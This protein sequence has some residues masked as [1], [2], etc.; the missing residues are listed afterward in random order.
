M[1]FADKVKNVRAKLLISQTE[2]AKKIG[3]S[4]ETINRWE[5]GKLQPS[6]LNE[7]RFEAFC[8]TEKINFKEI[9]K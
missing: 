1:N 7:K 5:T 8:E 6:F 3:V 9:K 4:F 2:L